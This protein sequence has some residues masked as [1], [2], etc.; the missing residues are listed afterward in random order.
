M[1]GGFLAWNFKHKPRARGQV[2]W[3]RWPKA[4]R[5]VPG[6][7]TVQPKLQTLGSCVHFGVMFRIF[8]RIPMHFGYPKYPKS[9]AERAPLETLQFW[10][11]STPLRRGGVIFTGLRMRYTAK[12]DH[13]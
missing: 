8:P 3:L 4:S 5:E 10:V 12:N 7:S 2:L 13:I 1:M 6:S 9:Q 11:S